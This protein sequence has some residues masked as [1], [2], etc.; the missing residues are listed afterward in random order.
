LP[1]PGFRFQ[2]RAMDSGSGF[3]FLYNLRFS[4]FSM[5]FEGHCESNLGC[6]DMAGEIFTISLF[7]YFHH[8]LN[9]PP[10]LHIPF[11]M[12]I[13]GVICLLFFTIVNIVWS[14]EHQNWHQKKPRQSRA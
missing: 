3:C 11:L 8:N 6:I 13:F 14:L 1:G 2:N 10:G 7:V 5:D 4:S 12:H 9:Y